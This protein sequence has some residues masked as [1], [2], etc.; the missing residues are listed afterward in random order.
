MKRKLF[1]ALLILTLLL[2]SCQYVPVEDGDETILGMNNSAAAEAMP[3]AVKPPQLGF[4]DEN[5]DAT[6]QNIQMRL[7][8]LNYLG[9]TADGIFG[10]ATEAALKDFQA[11]NNLPATGMADEVTLYALNSSRAR[12]MPTPEPTLL[13]TGAKGQGVK[14]VQN[15]LRVY[16][17]MAGSADGDFGELTRESVRSFQQYVYDYYRLYFE[18][19]VPTPMP[20][21]GFEPMA[22]P[23]YSPDGI[24][25]NDLEAYLLS[26]E[27]KPYRED[28]SRGK[29]GWEVLR[30]QKRLFSLNYLESGLDGIFGGNTEAALKYFQKRNGLQQTGYADEAVQLIL[31]SASAVKSDRPKCMYLLK[32]SVSDQKVYAYKWVN[33]EY[34]KHVRTMTCSTGT[35]DNPTPY[36]TFT[37]G[38]ACGRW[39]YFKEFDCW[40]QYAYRITGGILFHSV[41]YDLKDTST[42][43][44]SSVNNL[45]RRAS[46]GCIRL[47]V[48]DAKWIY[49]NCPAGTTVVVA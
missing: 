23:T 29:Q 33:G 1:A 21:P 17:F 40:A 37:A 7:I 4:K 34:N 28:V 47:K 42:L 12:P 14:D 6:V 3:E 39:Y 5:G 38:G 30:L 16:G 11:L 25:S 19:P 46:H 2:S 49:N 13:A 24:V 9:G 48:D 41:L 31:Y 36:G 44:Q 20:T 32:I 35:K 10:S 43:R 27:F 45:G 26:G 8:A 18:P 15:A 22:A